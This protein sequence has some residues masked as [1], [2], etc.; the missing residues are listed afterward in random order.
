MIRT[1]VW[2]VYFWAYMVCTIPVLIR[3]SYLEK[4]GRI[5]EKEKL[6]DRCVRKWAVSLVKL[7][8]SKIK[9][10]G[11][12]YIPE[13]P[14]VFVGNHQGNFDI[15]IFL[16][17]IKK[18]KA[19]ISKIEIRKLPIVS[20]WM[21]NMKCVFINRSDIRQSLKAMRTAVE[22]INQGYSMI[23][24]PEGTRSRADTLGEFKAGSFKL[25]LKSG[26]P[27]VPVTTKGSYKIMEK[28]G[29]I[30]KPAE[31]EV[32]ISKPIITKDLSREEAEKIP[33][34]VKNIIQSNLL[35]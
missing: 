34:Q 15:P 3:I 6:V 22:Y 24:F 25:A 8:G 27:I 26:V 2:F 17:Y 20:T 32:I 16:G 1:I 21:N 5:E 10:Y 31:V 13:G 9:V 14:V 35:A 33:S 28:N 30:I 7:T 23:I 18:P 19:F 29:F 4:H 11:E 12:E